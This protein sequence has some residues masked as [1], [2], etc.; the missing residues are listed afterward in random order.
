[1]HLFLKGGK[2][3]GLNGFR[4]FFGCFFKSCINVLVIVIF[5]LI[6]R[7]FFIVWPDGHHNGFSPHWL[8]FMLARQDAGVFGGGLWR[9]GH[10]IHTL[11]SRKLVGHGRDGVMM[12]FFKRR[13]GG[14]EPNFVEAGVREG[15]AVP[16]GGLGVCPGPVGDA[17]GRLVSND[18]THGTDADGVQ[19]NIIYIRADVVAW[20]SL[21]QWWTVLCEWAK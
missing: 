20:C 1:M 19:V 15:M 8:L 7:V 21:G 9:V 11:T 5:F 10:C 12:A 6:V 13:D 14:G 2:R 3:V 4:D 17:S 16:R 18:I